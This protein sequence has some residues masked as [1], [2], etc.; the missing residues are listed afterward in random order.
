MRLRLRKNLVNI[1]GSLL[2]AVCLRT[3]CAQSSTGQTKSAQQANAIPART[4]TMVVLGSAAPVPMAESP[5]S[6][7]VL[8][9]EGNKLAAETPLDFIRQDSSVF[10]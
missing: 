1:T 2:V 7:V 9:L 8:P 3:S 4:E 5:R 6:V 10:L